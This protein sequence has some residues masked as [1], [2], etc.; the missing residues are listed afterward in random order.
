MSPVNPE[1]ALAYKYATEEE[2]VCGW[3]WAACAGWGG[4]ILRWTAA[5]ASVVA[6]TCASGG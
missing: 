4:A 3:Q 5:S 1:R 6:S 2:G